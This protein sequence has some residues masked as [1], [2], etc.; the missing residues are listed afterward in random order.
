MG[1]YIVDHQGHGGNIDSTGKDVGRDENLGLT[2]A[3]RI[4]DCIAVASFDTTGQRGNRVALGNHTT[5]D[6]SGG[7]TCLE[8][9]SKFQGSNEA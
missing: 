4:N 2:A 5:L 8:F 3:E 1:T 6:F 9:V 7:M